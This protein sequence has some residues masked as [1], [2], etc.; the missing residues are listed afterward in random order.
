MKKVHILLLVLAFSAL[1]V[2]AQQPKSL[3]YLT[4]NADGVRSF[5]AHADKIDILVPTWYDVDENGLVSGGAD[6]MVLAAAKQHHIPVMPIVANSGFKQAEFHKLI[7]APDAYRQMISQ[8]VAAGKENGYSG[9]QFD[10]E[11]YSF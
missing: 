4:R 8:L 6:P 5:Y 3:F 11:N 2:E 9:F 1:T 10:F 7:T